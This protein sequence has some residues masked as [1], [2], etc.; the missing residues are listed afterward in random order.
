MMSL[1]SIA[2]ENFILFGGFLGILGGILYH[3]N[4]D[5]LKRTYANCM[6]GSLAIGFLIIYAPCV[7]MWSSDINNVI[8]LI[9]HLMLMF[10]CLMAAHVYGV[11]YKRVYDLEQERTMLLL[12][13]DF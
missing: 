4:S 5:K 11:L 8:K 12:R 2:I 7:Y 6:L 1:L 3:F 9:I 13:I 10:G